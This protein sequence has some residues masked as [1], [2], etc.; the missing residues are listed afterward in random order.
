LRRV[1]NHA[2]TQAWRGFG[3][4]DVR[5]ARAGAGRG[6]VL[7][8]ASGMGHGRKPRNAV[9]PTRFSRHPRHQPNLPRPRPSGDDGRRVGTHG[10]VALPGAKTKYLF[11]RDS[12]DAI[13]MVFGA[14]R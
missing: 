1:A 4:G 3:F 5:F 10:A 12:R 6:P 11:P 8:G 9:G 14:D 13:N 2:P 7:S